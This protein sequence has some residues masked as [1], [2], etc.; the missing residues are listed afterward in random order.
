[1]QPEI[2]AEPAIATMCT[3]CIIQDEAIGV[4]YMDMV[5][6]SM[7]RVGLSSSHM[8]TCS[9]GPTIEDFTDLS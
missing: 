9:P 6:P 2:L 3:S 5:T 4:T 8:A 1:M 7:G